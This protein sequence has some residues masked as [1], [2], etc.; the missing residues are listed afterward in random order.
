MAYSYQRERTVGDIMA[1][2]QSS[3]SD[4]SM[5]VAIDHV[6]KSC[7]SAGDIALQKHLVAFAQVS[8]YP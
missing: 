5:I 2:A 4:R 3:L 6:D 1:A 8:E 7:S